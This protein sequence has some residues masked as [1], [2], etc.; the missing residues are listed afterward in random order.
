MDLSGDQQVQYSEFIAASLQ[1]RF[2]SHSPALREAFQKFDINNTGRITEENLRTLLGPEFSGISVEEIFAAAD[3]DGDG[4]LEYDEF[5][6][7]VVGPRG[8]ERRSR[9][10]VMREINRIHG[11]ATPASSSSKDS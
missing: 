5:V 10:G 3:R 8:S 11:S 6:Q 2:Q 7:A 4:A 1:S 9:F